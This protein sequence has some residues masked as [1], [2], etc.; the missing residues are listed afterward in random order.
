MCT[1]EVTIGFLCLILIHV[2]KRIFVVEV[3]WKSTN[4][5]LRYLTKMCTFEVSIGLFHSSWLSHQKNPCYRCLM[6]ICQHQAKSF[7]KSIQIWSKHMVVPCYSSVMKIHQ[8]G[9]VIFNKNVHFWSKHRDA[10]TH[11]DCLIKRI[12]V[13]EV[14][15]KSINIDPRYVTKCAILKL[16]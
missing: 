16:P 15:W 6:K 2:I 7:N 1:F 9:A 4:M 5:E 8:H 3:S 13:I 12:P 14:S 11:F 10:F